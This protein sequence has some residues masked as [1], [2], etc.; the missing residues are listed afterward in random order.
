MNIETA[1]DHVRR[2]LD[3]VDPNQFMSSSR[4]VRKPYVAC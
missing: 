1:V 2:Q 4:C 3:K